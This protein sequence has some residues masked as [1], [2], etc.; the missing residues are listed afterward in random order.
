MTSARE[1]MGKVEI[2][3]L[4][5]GE[6]DGGRGGGGIRDNRMW[7]RYSGQKTKEWQVG[8]LKGGKQAK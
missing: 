8:V 1:E 6:Y 4:Q 7:K 2:R 3:A 5:V